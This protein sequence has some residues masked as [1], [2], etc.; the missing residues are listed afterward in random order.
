M[1]LQDMTIGSRELVA[2]GGDL[3]EFIWRNK[4]HV[5]SPETYHSAS[6]GT[7]KKGNLGHHHGLWSS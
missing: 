3:S 6:R 7:I 5:S 2:F 1:L 4:A